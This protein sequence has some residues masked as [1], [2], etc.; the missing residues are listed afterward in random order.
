[1]NVQDALK[2][3]VIVVEAALMNGQERDALRQSI[4]IV[5]QRCKIADD[6]EKQIA[7]KKELETKEDGDKISE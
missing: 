4:S 2:N 7:A 1:M 3:I 6:L 5:V